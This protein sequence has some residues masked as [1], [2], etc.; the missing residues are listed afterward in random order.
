MSPFPDFTWRQR[1]TP[2]GV[3]GVLL[4]VLMPLLAGVILSEQTSSPLRHHPMPWWWLSLSGTGF[5]VGILLLFLGREY[6]P[7]PLSETDPTPERPPPP[8]RAAAE[9]IQMR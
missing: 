2:L 9:F 5:Y 1:L 7:R 8:E 4:V 6:Y 3:C